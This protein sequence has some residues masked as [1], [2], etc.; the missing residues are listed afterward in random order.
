MIH[1]LKIE[2][3]YLVNLMESRKKSE[4]RANDRD[5][6]LG[7]TLKFWLSGRGSGIG[8]SVCFKVTHIHSGL[9]MATGYICLSLELCEDS[10]ENN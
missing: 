3:N 9:G 8:Q 4:I 7:D 1:K 6:Q 5:Y 10:D 2:K